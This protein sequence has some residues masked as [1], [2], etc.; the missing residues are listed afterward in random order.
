MIWNSHYF[1]VIKPSQ[2]SK[3]ATNYNK[4]SKL[5]IHSNSLEYVAYMHGNAWWSITHFKSVWENKSNKQGHTFRDQGHVLFARSLFSCPLPVWFVIT[6]WLNLSAEYRWQYFDPRDSQS[7]HM[8]VYLSQNCSQLNTL[9]LL[10]HR[11]NKTT[12]RT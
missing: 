7:N 4:N 12:Q 6:E 3:D 11:H 2:H 5:I 9:I 8:M 10:H 1:Q